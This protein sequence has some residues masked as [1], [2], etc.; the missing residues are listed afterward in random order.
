[1]TLTRRGFLTTTGAGAAG[2]ATASVWPHLAAAQAADRIAVGAIYDLSG[3]LQLFGQSQWNCAKM[4]IDE[5]NDA[6]G[7]L[8]KKLEVKSYDSQSQMQFYNQYANQLGLRDRVAVVQGG[9]TSA[10]RE[11]IRP[12]LGKLKTLYIYNT[13]YEGG[14]CDRNF[15]GTGSTPG[16]YV[17]LLVNEAGTRWGKKVYILAADYNYGQIT[18][19]W[20]HKATKEIG[21]S[22]VGEEFFPLDVNQFG[23]TISKIQSAKPDYVLNVFVGPAHASFYGQWAAAGMN[24]QIPQVSTTFG[25]GGEVKRMPIEITEGVMT[26]GSYYEELDTPIN[27]AWLAKFRARYGTDYGYLTDVSVK[28]WYGWHLWAAAVKAAGSVDRDKVIK[29]MEGGLQIDGPGGVVKIDAKT[30]H[31]SMDM[32]LS[33]AKGGRFEIQKKFPNVAPTNTGGE[34]DLI[35]RPDTNVMFEPKI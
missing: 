2:L 34:C 25:A 7:V 31:T 18:A 33:Q 6:G 29:V 3:P 22:V 20:V 30:H 35:A 12:N 8:G 10:S 11:V 27:K 15:F 32:Y 24:K 19:K 4:A 14:V 9:L 28:E 5:I 13:N 23:P 16:G 21:G 1:M 26:P 17:D